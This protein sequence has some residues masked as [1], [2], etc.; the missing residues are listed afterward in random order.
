MKQIKLISLGTMYV[1][2]NCI[3]FPFDKGLFAH[4]E[5][6]GN[7]YQLELGGSALNFAKLATQLELQ[8]TFIGKVGKDMMGDVLITLLK[9][10]AIDSAVIIDGKVQTNLAVHYIHEDGSSIMTSSGSA[11]QALN[12]QEI[13]EKLD[14]ND[15]ADFLYL[16]GCF[17]LKKLLPYLPEIAKEA[18]EK[19]M[20][21]VL[22]HGR[23]NNSVTK[24]DRDAIIQLIPYIDIYLPSIDEFLGLWQVKTIEEGRTKIKKI[25]ESQIV[26]KQGDLGAVGFQNDQPISVPAFPVSIINTVGAGDSFNAGFIKAL[27]LN[28]SFEE[29]MRYACATAAAKISSLDPISASSVEKIIHLLPD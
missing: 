25:S 4:R 2:I 14:Q 15:M 1:D 12:Y 6:T 7:Q 23:I 5:T 28:T 24:K 29:S 16:G 8:T 27:S 26:I 17:K 3:N 22:D 10:N 20:Q 11:N 21:V 19:G 18:Q 9:Q 13:H